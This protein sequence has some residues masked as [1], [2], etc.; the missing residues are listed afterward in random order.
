[1]K[2]FKTLILFLFIPLLSIQSQHVYVDCEFGNDK[3]EGTKE[4]PVYSIHRALELVKNEDNEF[5]GV[6]INPGIYVL[7]NYLSVLC[8]KPIQNKRLIIEASILPGDS[9]WTLECMPVIIN[10][11]K[12]GQIQYG[13]HII[14]SFL[15]ESDHVT[16]RGLKFNGHFNPTSYYFPIARYNRN[17]ADLIVEQC[18]FVGDFQ[19]AHIQVGVIAHGSNVKIDHC[20]FYQTKNAVVFFKEDINGFKLGNSITNS[21]VY[22]A[23]H[24]IWTS[25]SDTD[26]TFNNN[27]VS[28]CKYFWIKNHFN[29]TI[30]RITN[31]VIVNNESNYGVWTND[32]IIPEDFEVK[33]ENLTKTGDIYLRIIENIDDPVPLDYLHVVTDSL[34][35]EIKAGLFK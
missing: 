21:I 2:H 23:K 24:A 17:R 9:D 22:G 32:G 15:I 29:T 4:S 19:A 30:Y 20:I 12:K 18:M 31:S 14:A 34:G 35:Y 27:I 25:W 16:I 7:D 11:T 13:D 8:D 26:F 5:Y 1:M 28:N 6:K 33:E 3:N 10:H